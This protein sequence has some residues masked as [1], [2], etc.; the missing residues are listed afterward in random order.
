MTKPPS[1]IHLINKTHTEPLKHCKSQAQ[2]AL[3]IMK[4]INTI[5]L[6]Q[7]TLDLY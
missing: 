7:A 5:L 6:W 2:L 3:E 4:F 1:H